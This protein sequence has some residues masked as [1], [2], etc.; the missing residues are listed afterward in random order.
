MKSI[1]S[2]LILFL[3]AAGIH[4]S[5]VR[6]MRTE[7]TETLIKVECKNDRQLQ[8]T[9][10]QILKKAT[11]AD[12]DI[13]EDYSVVYIQARYSALSPVEVDEIRQRL[14]ELP[15]VLDLEIKKDGIPV[16]TFIYRREL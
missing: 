15:G 10:K 11:V 9:V 14:T 5:P 7:N 6:E 12:W 3:L 16:K 1:S 8:L 4:C 2:I 13:R